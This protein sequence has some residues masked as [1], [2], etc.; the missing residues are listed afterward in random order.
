MKKYHIIIQDESDFETCKTVEASDFYGA[1]QLA[2]GIRDSLSNIRI[3]QLRIT[4]ITE[5]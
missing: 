1:F 2:L 5:I 3:E 4:Q